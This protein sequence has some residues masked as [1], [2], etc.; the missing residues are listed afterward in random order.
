[1]VHKGR[2]YE[3]QR[4]WRLHFALDVIVDLTYDV[5]TCMPVRPAFAARYIYIYTY[6]YI[7]MRWIT[8][9]SNETSTISL[10]TGDSQ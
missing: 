7:Y 3:R 8:G 5:T 9:R 4:R 1:M 6:I 2:S 10:M